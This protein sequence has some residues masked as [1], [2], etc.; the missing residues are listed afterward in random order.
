M[1]YDQ[2]VDHVV[3]GG[4]TAGCAI[5]Y[6]LSADPSTTVLLLEAGGSD[7]DFPISRVDLPS[8]FSLWGP[9]TDWGYSTEENP[10]L[11]GRKVPIAQGRVLGGSSS[12]NARIFLR[13]NRRDYD[14]WNYLGNEGWGYT[15]VLP[16]LKKG[17]NYTGAA[18][19]YRGAGGPV[20]VTDLPEPSPAAQAFVQ[21]S[22]DLLKYQGPPW[23][24]NG[25][26][27]EGGVG[28]CQSTMT[29]ELVRTNTAA[30]YVDPIRGRQNFTLELR[31]H[32][33]R[34]LFEGNRAVGVEYRQDGQ[35]RRVRANREVTLSAGAFG[36]PKLLMLSGIGPADQLAAHDIPV[37][38]DL[39][40]VGQNLQDHL[41]IQMA[42]SCKGEQPAPIILSETTLF[43]HTRHAI[44]AASPDLQYLFSAFLFPGLP[45]QGPG[46]TM[47]PVA[48]QPWSVG[49]VGL[50]SANPFD[51]PRIQ[52]N[53]LSSDIDRQ[54]LLTGIRLG[55][56]LVH[57]Q[58]FKDVVD[59]ELLPG[60]DKTTD[61]ELNDYIRNYCLTVWHPCG[62][63]KMGYDQRAVVD[64]Q[65]RVH[66]IGGLRIADA[67][68]MPRI[69]NANLQ[70]TCIMIGEKA[71]D[72]IMTG[73]SL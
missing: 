13:G 29:G 71:A 48:A 61:Q 35:L 45:H 73:R 22:V 50:R 46:F 67:S 65:L 57:S 32:T 10:R 62:T 4:G 5:A 8:L 1:K 12:I 53:Y 43:V 41:L 64:P 25:P 51:P 40:G 28:F 47:C 72:L 36:S 69:V 58:A 14:H 34:L 16:Y 49:S 26:Q 18:S 66:G 55:R 54:V 59:E 19:E 9:D 11:N 15:D 38:L 70:A 24:F 30:A 7:K 31:A 42:Y 20:T 39:P 63:C 44:K 6:R 68:I 52:A 37:L 27:Q 17:E 56:E 23:D 33:T 21:A 60:A 2:V 3:I